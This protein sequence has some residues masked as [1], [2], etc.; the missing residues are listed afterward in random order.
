MF[1]LMVWGCKLSLLKT[2]IDV[3]S[4]TEQEKTVVEQCQSKELNER[5]RAQFLNGIDEGIK[6]IVMSHDQKTFE[7]ALLV[8]TR[9]EMIETSD[10]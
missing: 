3:E 1:K 9:E 2:T 4:V 8:A 5:L 7:E 6:R 10:R